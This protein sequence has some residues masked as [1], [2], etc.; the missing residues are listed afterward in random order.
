RASEKGTKW[1]FGTPQQDIRAGGT[2]NG[3]LHSAGFYAEQAEVKI[4]ESGP[5]G[6]AGSYEEN[7]FK[8]WWRLGYTTHTSKIGL[9]P[10]LDQNIAP[11]TYTT[12]MTLT[13]MPIAL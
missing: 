10:L 8:I 1:D 11:G 6:N 7:Q 3:R 9:P 5:E 12:T 4:L 13:A 2:T